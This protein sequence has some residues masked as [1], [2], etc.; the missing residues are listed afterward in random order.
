MKMEKIAMRMTGNKKKKE[1]KR[2]DGM[3][4]M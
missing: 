2:Y 3:V 4:E 1:K